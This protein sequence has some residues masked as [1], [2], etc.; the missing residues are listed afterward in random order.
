MTAAAPSG[1][2]ARPRLRA[3]ARRL[4][5]WSAPLA[6][7]LFAAAGLAAAGDYGVT[8]DEP[9]QRHL[10]VM[11]A[12]YVR[13]G[14]G[15]LLDHWDRFYG[16]GFELPLLLAERALG[17]DDL[18]DAYLARHVL[19]H[20]FFVAGG[21][22][23]SLLAYRL[24]GSRAAALAALLLFLLHPRLYAH[25]F[26][27]SKDVPF[28]AMFTICLL[29]IHRAFGKND[30]ASFVLCGA[31]VGLLVNIRIAGVMLFLAVLGMRALDLLLAGSARER[32]RAAAA[33]AAFALA[34][35]LALYAT[36]PWLWTDPLGRF[37]EAL[38][39][40]SRFP[41]FVDELFRGEYVPSYDPPPAYVPGWFLVTTPPAAILLGLAGAAA[42]ARR[43]AARPADALRNTD[44][45]FGLLLAG[46]VAL[47]VAAAILLDSNLYNGWRQLYFLYGPVCLLAACGL[48]RLASLA[49]RAGGP[50]ARGAVYVLAG[51]GLAVALA[52]IVR[53]HPQQHAYF[54]LLADREAPERLR[55]QYALD[56][57]G[58]SYLEALRHLLELRPD[59]TIAVDG[60]IDG[61]RLIPLAAEDR[62]RIVVSARPDYRVTRFP[63]RYVADFAGAGNDS[64]LV[65]W[66]RTVYGST[67]VAVVAGEASPRDFGVRLEGDR[68]AYV[69]EDCAPEDTERPFFLHVRP[70]RERDLR[71]GAARGEYNVL[72]FAFR[73]RGSASGG[74]CTAAIALPSYPIDRIRTGQH[75]LW[76]HDRTFRP[77]LFDEAAAAAW[78]GQYRLRTAG[79][80][81]VRSGYDLYLRGGALT[82]ARDSCAREDTEARFFLHVFP[83][84]PDDLPNPH[85]QSF[86][87]SLDFA[88]HEGGGISGGSCMITIAL[89]SYPI[90]RIRTGQFGGGGDPIWEETFPPDP[91]AWRERF[92][93]LAARAPAARAAFDVHL[94]GRTLTY[95]RDGCGEADAAPRF[96]LHVVPAD[97]D[98]L[99]AD[100][101]GPG[102]D[103]LDFAFRDRGVRY[104]GKCLATAALPAY[105]IARVRTGQWVRGE[106]EVWRAE[107]AVPR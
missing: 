2:P 10:A 71:P 95:A 53:L 12:D 69:R 107:F 104:G 23:C 68:L 32:R 59:G 65:L 6:C 38:A 74:T 58:H 41:N 81:A 14:D 31:A 94:D 9:V 22:C 36:W 79:E 96:F 57:W 55:A 101:R 86:Y 4:R 20:L 54:N 88:F 50:G 33:A 47:P 15:R 64:P 85:R 102:F 26:F 67:L 45:R 1:P 35:A 63:E 42:L 16:V 75:P 105:P 103:N 76:L 43:C 72:D 13:H 11:T 66:R 25:S 30:L 83:A 44:L 21:F 49:G 5:A 7:A 48:S 39:R 70:A 52:S 87:D 17:L 8:A 34:A 46:C 29:L 84:D 98:D 90:D 80:P 61:Y 106:G 51:A 56:Y 91:G 40:M 97:A 73:E 100:R 27:N 77:P 89:P 19:T 78:R 24:T 99:P 82:Y 62:G 60:E 28:L 3:A 93:A 92:G 37:A 18:R